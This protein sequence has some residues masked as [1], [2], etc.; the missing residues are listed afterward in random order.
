[1]EVFLMLAIAQLCATVVVGALIFY[2]EELKG[3][4]PY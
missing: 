3:Y 1:M 2:K 4:R